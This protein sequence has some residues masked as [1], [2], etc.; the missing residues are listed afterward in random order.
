M[1]Y[2]DYMDSLDPMVDFIYGNK[3]LKSWWIYDICTTFDMDA[4]R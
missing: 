2:M 1:D 3:T 4:I